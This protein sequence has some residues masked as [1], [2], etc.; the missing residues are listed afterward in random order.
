MPTTLSSDA[1]AA[2]IGVIRDARREAG[3]TQAQ[4]AAKIGQPQSFI[5]KSERRERRIDV[6][7]FL[8]IASALDVSPTEL[9]VR[10]KK[11]ISEL[12]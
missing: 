5:S 4:V 1:Y 7:E 10:V 8:D 6:V 2:F 9:L 3:L 11:A 12:G